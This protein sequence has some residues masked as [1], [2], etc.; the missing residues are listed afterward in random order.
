MNNSGLFIIGGTAYFFIE[1]LWRGYSHITMFVLGGL[2]FILIGLLNEFDST[3]KM[4]LLIQQVI[5]CIIITTLELIFGLVFNVWLKMNIW[6]YSSLKF[7]FMG[8]IS[9]LFSILWFLIS[10]PAII[11]D[12]YI[13]F[14][15]FG[16]EK[17]D[18]LN[19]YMTRIYSLINVYKK[20]LQIQV[21]NERKE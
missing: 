17:P 19:E 6:D 7:N 18:Y 8:Q 13:R 9:L 4:P 11:L 1:I 21:R 3:H 5:S 10:L 12:D 15:L 2:C 14:W 20:N 16:E